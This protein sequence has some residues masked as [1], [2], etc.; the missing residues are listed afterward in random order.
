MRLIFPFLLF[1]FSRARAALLFR[2]FTR[3]RETEENKENKSE[4]LSTDEIER[5]RRR[6]KHSTL[7]SIKTHEA[8]TEWGPGENEKRELLINC[9]SHASLSL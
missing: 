9:N 7:D 6:L 1:F 5:R 8:G 4:S 3:G 2:S